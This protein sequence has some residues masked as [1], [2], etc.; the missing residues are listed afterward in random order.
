M[1]PRTR[2]PAAAET[3]E[4]SAPAGTP[5][6]TNPLRSLLLDIADVLTKHAN[7]MPLTVEANGHVPPQASAPAVEDLPWD[8]GPSDTAAAEPEP[9]VVQPKPAARKATAKKAAPKAAVKEIAKPDEPGE[10]AELTP[11]QFEEQLLTMAEDE[12]RA[13]AISMSYD[14]TSVAET[15]AQDIVV[16][17]LA[18]RFPNYTPSLH[19]ALEDAGRAMNGD[20]D[21]L[22][23]EPEPETPAGATREE[24]QE[25]NLPTLRK[26]AQQLGF[27][28]DQYKGLDVDAIIELILSFQNGQ[29]DGEGEADAEEG[30]YASEDD[31]RNMSRKELWTLVTT[32]EAEGG[33]GYNPPRDTPAETMVDWIISAMRGEAPETPP[34]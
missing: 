30:G 17:L 34:Y 8:E 15:G 14:P 19:E 25:M 26:L 13:L 23:A 7:A 5:V 33:L 3:V 12:L 20:P 31:I 24:L 4:V 18:E 29:G 1:P 10:A 27:E 28:E 6:T 9:E 22:E 11:E 2:K 21:D 32:P 16:T